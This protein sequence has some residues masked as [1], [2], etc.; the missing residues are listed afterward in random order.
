MPLKNADAR[1]AIA[2]ATILLLL[3]VAATALARPQF[4]SRDQIPEK[5]KWRLSDIYPGWDEWEADMTRMEE[6]MERYAAF[7]GTLD[8][9]PQRLL[10][11]N[12]LGDEMGV[13]S[14]KLYRY[15]ALMYSL[16]TR[17]N[18]ISARLQRVRTMFARF[19]TATAWFNPEMLRIPWETM[20]GWLDSTPEMAPYR[21]GIED[22]YRQQAHVL[23]EDK[24]K[25]LSFYGP[26]RGTPSDIYA[27]LST[28]DIK[29]R[30][31]ELADGETVT[32]TPG[33]YYNIL[34]TDPDQQNRRTA[35]EAF[36]GVYN[37]QANTYA[38]IYNSVLQRDWAAAQARGYESCLQ[39]QL[40]G[41]NIPTAVY[42]NLVECVR[43][44]T[45]PMHRY[46][47]LRKKALGLDE[48]HGY[49]G[50][51]TLV[52]FNKE[53]PYDEIAGDIVAS[54]APLGKD[55]Q[56]KM[57][58]IFSGGWIDVYESQGKRSGAFSSNVYGV[59][60]YIMLNYND[61]LD[62]FFTAAHE[63]GH[64]MHTLL[65]NENQPFSTS[66]YTI[67]VAEVASTLN[68][69]LLL[70]HMLQR[71]D[72]PVERAAL[73]VHAI[74]D[75]VSTFYSQV[76]FADF[77]WR[78]HKMVEAGEPITADSLSELYAELWKNQQGPAAT[79]DEPYRATWTR[80]G[81]FYRT[82]FYVY[83]YATCYA[84]S[85]KLFAAIRNGSEQERREA[86][87]RYLDLLK[88][89]GNDYPM[90][91]LKKAGVDL[92]DPSAFQAVVDNLD[93]LVDQLEKELE[94]M[95]RI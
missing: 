10:E 82:P 4:E 12:R 71:T 66:S 49:D 5:Y 63:A 56:K 89:G 41:D 64:S 23:S 40:D 38:S 8:Q 47:A 69:R 46:I 78:A 55:Y 36:Y 3:A 37:D 94:R 91:Q 34:S 11:A 92:S 50:S 75:I 72:D 88:S 85:A 58:G 30:D 42:E 84:S 93:G 13:M 26:F 22:L 83:Q 6:L 59:H 1:R 54:V 35:F 68:E 65:S 70:D 20:K 73:L 28:S 76:M 2:A 86:T 15:P 51:A 31:V 81:H 29:F 53:Y 16:D 57:K 79:F 77:E 90:E 67:F 39:A 43:N 33:T 60:P 27:Q 18:D 44:G 48:Y 7:E 87:E 61:T 62:N 21:F 32:V 14:Y 9:G 45:G 19:S 74:D 95:G 24:E 80:I 52:D 17:D 25:L